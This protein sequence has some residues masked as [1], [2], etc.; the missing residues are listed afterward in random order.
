MSR[1]RAGAP[2]FVVETKLLASANAVSCNRWLSGQ[3]HDLASRFRIFKNPRTVLPE[4]TARVESGKKVGPEFGGFC[5]NWPRY[6]LLPIDPDSWPIRGKVCRRECGASVKVVRRTVPSTSVIEYTKKE[7]FEIHR[8]S[9]AGLRLCSRKDALASATKE[10][11]G[12][13]VASR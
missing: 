6:Y 10:P 13:R 12:G 8:G 1:R 3:L 9:E 4:N 7:P 2:A 5:K 11:E